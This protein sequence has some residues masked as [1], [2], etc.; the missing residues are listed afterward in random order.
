VIFGFGPIASLTLAVLV[1][2]AA[3]GSSAWKVQNWRAASK[4]LQLQRAVEAQREANLDLQRAAEKRY[5]VQ[6]AA[7]ERVITQT[8]TEVRYAAQSLASCPVP[9]D[10]RRLLNE[11][12]R[13]ARG[14]SAS[15]CGAD[16]AVPAA[17]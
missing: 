9:A 4:E 2:F 13:C 8:I 14:D 10:A 6:A 15:A 1:G 5:V 3:G 17:R 11:A 7:R 12:A 16:D